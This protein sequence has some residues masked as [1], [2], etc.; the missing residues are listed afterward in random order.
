LFPVESIRES[1][2]WIWL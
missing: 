1:L 2:A